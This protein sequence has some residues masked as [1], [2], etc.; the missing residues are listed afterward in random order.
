MLDG[1]QGRPMRAS[2][3]I[4]DHIGDRKAKAKV[5][6]PTGQSI[7]VVRIAVAAVEVA[8]FRGEK[9]LCRSVLTAC[10]WARVLT[11]F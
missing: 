11:Q 4:V 5:I 6:C 7:S 2:N 8:L 1:S 10:T 9:C 3:P